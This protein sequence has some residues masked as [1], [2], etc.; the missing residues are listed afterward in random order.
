[1]AAKLLANVNAEAQ[2]LELERPAPNAPWALAGQHAPDLVRTAPG[3]YSLVHQGRSYKVLVVKHDAEARTTQLR[4]GGHSYTVRMEDERAMLMK[5]L[6][7]GQGAKSV[8]RELKAPM[9][10]LVLKVLVK[11][12]DAVEKNDPL[13]VLEAMKM[14]NVIKSAGEGVV[15]KIHAV[16]RNAVEKGQL[17]IGFE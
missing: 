5:Q 14:E 4:V 15:K 3:T 7:I 6:G 16:E 10:G 12:G 11:E 2:P 1:M 17:L 13:L 9:P 8:V